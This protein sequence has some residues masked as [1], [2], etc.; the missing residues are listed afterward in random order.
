M[1]PQ[2]TGQRSEKK[3]SKTGPRQYPEWQQAVLD[4]NG[5]IFMLFS[6]L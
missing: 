6:V 1:K 2:L 5:G 4:I 3:G